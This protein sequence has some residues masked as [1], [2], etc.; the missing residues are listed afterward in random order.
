MGK[1]L[2]EVSSFILIGYVICLLLLTL[3]QVNNL[4]QIECHQRICHFFFIVKRTC[5]KF[6]DLKVNTL[7][8]SFQSLPEAC[9]FS[10]IIMT[11]LKN[12]VGT[13]SLNTKQFPAGLSHRIIPNYPHNHLWETLAMGKNP[14]RQPRIYSIPPTEKSPLVNLLLLSKLSFLPHQTVIFI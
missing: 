6:I 5:Y 3:M 1:M 11:Y 12:L 4:Q 9:I 14:T 10:S 7:T 13:K 2:L 8:Q